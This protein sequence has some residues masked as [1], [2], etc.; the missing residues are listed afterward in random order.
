MATLYYNAAVDNDW[1]TLGNWWT[2]SGHT[3]AAASLPTS[4]DSVVASANINA[5]GGSMPTVVNFTTTAYMAIQITVTGVATFSGSGGRLT[6]ENN[7]GAEVIGNA[8]FQ[9]GATLWQYATVTGNATFHDTAYTHPQ[10]SVSGDVTVT[11]STFDAYPLNMPASGGVGGTVTFSSAT[12]VVFNLSSFFIGP[13]N[14]FEPPIPAV[15]SFT[16]GAPTWHLSAS[17]IRQALPGNVVLSGASTILANVSGSLTM[18]G[19][20]MYGGTV[21]GNATFSN[22]AIFYSGNIDGNATFTSGG[23]SSG[24]AP[25][26]S[27]S[28]YPY[29]TGTS[30]FTG[31]GSYPRWTTLVGAVS[32]D[33]AA[34]Q[35][36]LEYDDSG[37]TTSST[38]T[39]TYGKG[40]NGS[41]ILG[42]V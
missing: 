40:V 22:S 8:V 36:L 35:S 20:G 17:D 26:G 29:I 38:V 41:S 11:A 27:P 14:N 10:C 6:N 39:I 21:S 37:N 9:N 2:D 18:S 25:F 15:G 4:S 12:P 31:S 3:S 1:N 23:R 33:V 7:T 28:N 5:N 16:A 34:A 13:L 19:G 42:V 30:T 32:M 24:D